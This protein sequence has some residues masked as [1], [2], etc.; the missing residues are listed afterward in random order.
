MVEE[1]N[2]VPWEMQHIFKE[3]QNYRD[4]YRSYEEKSSSVADTTWADASERSY[5]SKSGKEMVKKA[6]EMAEK[7][8]KWQMRKSWAEYITH[9][10]T[11]A[12]MTLPYSPGEVLL[13]SILL[14]DVLEDTKLTYADLQELSQEVADIVE[15]AT[16][17]RTISAWDNKNG[18]KEAKFETIRK[19]LI[20]SQRD[21]RILFLKVFDRLHNMITLDAQIKRMTTE[22]S[23]RNSRYLCASSKKVLTQRSTSLPPMISHRSTRARGVGDNENFCRK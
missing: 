19:I 3:L 2:Q 10:L 12:C 17:I 13:S 1:N 11:I 14:H 16:K 22:N 5:V 9:P 7:W 20:A 4:T 8:H 23:R 21:I 18:W 6:F 15:W